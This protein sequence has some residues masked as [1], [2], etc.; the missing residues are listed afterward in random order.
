MLTANL[1]EQLEQF[2]VKV[3]ESPQEYKIEHKAGYTGGGSL[4]PVSLGL[5]AAFGGAPFW[6]GRKRKG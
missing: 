4:D 1:K 5:L 6:S 3:K 2:K